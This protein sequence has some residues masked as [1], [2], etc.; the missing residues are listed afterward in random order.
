MNAIGISLSGIQSSLARFDAS[1]ARVASASAN[2]LMPD[3]AAS[4]AAQAGVTPAPRQAASDIDIASEFILVAATLMRIKAKMLIPRKEIDEDGN[5]ID[6]RQEL[7]QKL[8]L[9]FS[10]ST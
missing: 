10:N 4:S 8:L 5:E 2:P 1:A 6:P 9:I 3:P 7:T